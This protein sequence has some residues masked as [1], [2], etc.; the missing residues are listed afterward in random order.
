M[1]N[2]NRKHDELRNVSVEVLENGFAEG[3]CIIS[4][5]KTN[6][7]LGRVNKTA[8]IK[9]HFK[10]FIIPKKTPMVKSKNVNL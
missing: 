8:K 6:K 7:R 10:T 9:C 5:G 1:R 4:F 3:G 2:F